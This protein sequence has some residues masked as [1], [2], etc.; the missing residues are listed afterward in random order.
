[1]ALR[2]ESGKD[3]FD[4]LPFIAIMMCVIGCLLLV[5]MSISALS[6]GPG[7]GEGWVP[8]RGRDV[9]QKR[10]VLIEW[11]G[12][13]AIIHREGG[14]KESFTWSKPDYLF[15]NI[16]GNSNSNSNNNSKVSTPA[17]SNIS[18]TTE[19]KTVLDELADKRATHYALFAVRPSG[20]ESFQQFADVFRGRQID[21]GY[22]PI[23]QEKAVR[24]FKEKTQP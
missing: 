15:S 13:T 7:L 6:I 5:T 23:K 19:L 12:T 18:S 9:A 10:P 3:H 14:R 8:V 17:S 16:N 21:V 4:L 1:M 2:R 22:E 24:L 11:D 20:F